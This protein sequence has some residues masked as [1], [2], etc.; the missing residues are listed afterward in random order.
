MNATFQMEDLFNVLIELETQG[1]KNYEYL[2]SQ[3]DDQR[4]IGFFLNLAKQ[5]LRHKAIYEG[6]KKE[7]LV[8]EGSKITSEYK[9]YMSVL[10]YNSISILNKKEVIEDS[11]IAYDMAISLEKDTILF[12]N[13]M[14]NL[15]PIALHKKI[16]TLMDEERQH[17]KF[18][19]QNKL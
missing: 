18:L 19:Y 8:F 6:Y 11:L 9:E 5:E 16:D 13:E 14:K 3:T 1:S 2:A 15:I 17:L 4:M 12:L 7:F 10:L